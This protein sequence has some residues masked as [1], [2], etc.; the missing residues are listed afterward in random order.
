V[1]DGA[2]LM[3]RVR[4]RDVDAFE[5]LYDGYHRLVFGIALRIA[6]DAALAEDLTQS[7]FLKLWSS[8]ETFREGNF[9]GWLSRVTRNHA[10]D[11]VRSRANR[12]GGEMPA[13]IPAEASTDA[14]VFA[15]IDAQRVRG[16][17]SA[18][19]EEQRTPIELGFFAGIT[20]EEIAL[21]TGI[22][23]GTI[24]TRIRTGL[25]RMRESLNDTVSR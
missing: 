4:A 13:E 21:R 17:L 7:I 6:S 10:L 25:R 15:R 8:P 12:S 3:E 14:T 2:R 23:L 20:H 1:E 11:V 22:P 24:K 16:A 9:A 5:R 19:S 18:L